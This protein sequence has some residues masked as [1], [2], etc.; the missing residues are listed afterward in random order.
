MPALLQAT[1]SRPNQVWGKSSDEER[2]RRSI[3]IKV[4]RSLLTPILSNIDLADTD[5]A[6]PVRFNTTTPT[7][8]LHVLNGEFTRL[9]ADAY[10]RRLTAA[11]GKNDAARGRRGLELVTG[12]E[13]GDLRVREHLDFLAQLRSDHALDDHD[14]LKMF[15][16]VWLN[17]NAF[18][19]LD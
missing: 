5:R 8:A 3:Y 18:M 2:H 19:Y 15:C 4:K 6:C 16:L 10:A 12:R 7:Q 17:A 9:M 14:A 13:P 11:H 1:S